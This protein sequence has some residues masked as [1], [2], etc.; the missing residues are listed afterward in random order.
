MYLI[1]IKSINEGEWSYLYILI[2]S[3]SR[4]LKDEVLLYG[5]ERFSDHFKHNLLTGNVLS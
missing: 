5:F 4:K 3:L 2:H 1:K